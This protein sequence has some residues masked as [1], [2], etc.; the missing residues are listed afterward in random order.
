MKLPP[1]AIREFQQ[2][3]SEATGHEL[4]ETEAKERA[5]K[6]LTLLRALSAPRNNSPP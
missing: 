4:N 3:W 6:V 2:A 1:A 5:E